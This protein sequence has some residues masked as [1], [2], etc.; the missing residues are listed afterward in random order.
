MRQ[1]FT[2]SLSQQH[3]QS[4]LLDKDLRLDYH[5]QLVYK[6]SND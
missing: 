6:P 5:K 2:I 3:R 4:L 1:D